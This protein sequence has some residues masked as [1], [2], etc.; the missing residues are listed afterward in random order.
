MRNSE[1]LALK[2]WAREHMQDPQ[3]IPVLT[4]R[5]KLAVR[6]DKLLSDGQ[7]RTIETI[8]S[9]LNTKIYKVRDVICCIR[10]EWNYESI[11]SVHR[12]YRKDCQKY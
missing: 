6:I 3:K 1:F 8:A 5:E 12:G 2:N 4:E 7:W 11:P 10:I 9:E